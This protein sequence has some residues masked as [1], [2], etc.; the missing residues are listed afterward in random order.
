MQK[1]LEKINDYNVML[2]DQ[3]K[4][5]RSLGEAFKNIDDYYKAKKFLKLGLMIKEKTEEL[6]VEAIEKINTLYLTSIQ[7]NEKYYKAWHA[8]ALINFEAA[9]FHQKINGHKSGMQSVNYRDLQITK[10]IE[11]AVKGFIKSISLG[12]NQEK[13]S[14]FLLQDS[15]RLL[16]MIFK[17]GDIELVAQGFESHYKEI[18][19]T[20]WIDV[21]PQ[22][23]ARITH[24][25]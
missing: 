16:S 6:T 1:E 5:G 15:L 17:Y 3:E 19:I 8:Y 21:V 4:N 22:I 20:A 2:V 14:R 7:I 18:D 13:K 24:K 9:E 12:C 23:I 10:Y 25:S 11:N